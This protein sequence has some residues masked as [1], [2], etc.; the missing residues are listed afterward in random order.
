M[1][2]DLSL[3]RGAVRDGTGTNDAAMITF[4]SQR[5]RSITCTPELATV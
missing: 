1:T 4:E 3:L 5:A 2:D